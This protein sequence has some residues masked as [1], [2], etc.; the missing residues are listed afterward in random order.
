MDHKHFLLKILTLSGVPKIITFGL[1]IISFPILIRSIGAAEYGE[2]LMVGA[3]LGIFEMLMNFG[4][5]SAAGKAMAN[6]RAYNP[7]V[8]FKQFLFWAQLQFFTAAIGFVPMVFAANFL[9]N[10]NNTLSSGSELLY[11]MSFTVVTQLAANF[12]RANLQSLLAFKSLAILDTIESVLRSA[13]YLIV[14]CYFATPMGFAL[15]MLGL[16]VVVSGLAGVMISQRL[17]CNLNEKCNLNLC[18]GT[19][20]SLNIVKPKLMD[21]INFFWLGLSTRIFH[22]GPLLLIGRMMGSEVVGII[23]AFSRITEILSTPYLII[24]NALMVQV[25][26]ISQ[27]GLDALETLWDAA[28]RIATTSILLS[29]VI[30][31]AAEPLAHILLPE[32]KQAE[33]FFSTMAWLIAPVSIMCIFAPISDYMGGL[34]SRNILLTTIAC[35]QL[36]ILWLGTFSLESNSI[37][38]AYVSIYY[39]LALAY[40]L[41]AAKVIFT[42][43]TIRI[44]AGT[45]LY[46][47]IVFLALFTVTQLEKTTLVSILFLHENYFNVYIEIALFLSIV[48]TGIWLNSNTRKMYLNKNF[49]EIYS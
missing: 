14:A 18:D 48:I 16:S 27:R 35:L 43:Y 45:K 41:I 1:T 17:T 39:I 32:N 5:A 31:L 37:I 24:G 30:Y 40:I 20:P 23:G 25:N 2:V 38:L 6:N 19:T 46:L 13:G 36:P 28:L 9:L 11:V 34:I 44:Q 10:G 3:A 15:M 8:V 42:K 33:E 26:A 22:Q 7:K 21:C 47:A 4:V 49:F 29:A 12:I